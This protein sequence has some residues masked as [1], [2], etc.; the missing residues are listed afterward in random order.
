MEVKFSMQENF[1]S[2]TGSISIRVPNGY[3]NGSVSLLMTM[4]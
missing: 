2:L 1:Q 4:L 3:S